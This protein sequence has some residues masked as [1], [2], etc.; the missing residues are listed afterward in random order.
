M[1]AQKLT[2]YSIA[3]NQKVRNFFLKL[4]IFSAL[5]YRRLQSVLLFRFCAW[6]YRRQTALKYLKPRRRRKIK[7]LSHRQVDADH[8]TTE[9]EEEE[10]AVDQSR[11]SAAPTRPLI[12]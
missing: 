1:C 12:G 2:V 9:E 6:I 7:S 8:M 11:V 3:Q 4:F 5:D 10:E